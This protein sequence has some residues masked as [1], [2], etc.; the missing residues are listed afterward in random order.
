MSVAREQSGITRA[1]LLVRSYWS[2]W[3]A[4][5]SASLPKERALRVQAEHINTLGPGDARTKADQVEI[6]LPAGQVLQFE[7]R[8]PLDAAPLLSAIVES[9]A[10]RLTPYPK[11]EAVIG[12]RIKGFDFAAREVVITAAA[13][14][15]G[16]IEALQGALRSAGLPFSRTAFLAP[17]D[18]R[19][20]RSADRAGR[21]HRISPRLALAGLPAFLVAAALT[22]PLW[23]MHEAADYW[24]KRAAV[25]ERQLGTLS[26]A[27]DRVDKFR[28]RSDRIRRAQ[29]EEAPGFDVL[30]HLSE[31]F[32]DGAWLQYV[33]AQKNALEM[34]GLAADPSDVVNR[35]TASP[36]FSNV[37]YKSA[38]GRDPDTSLSRFDLKAHMNW[39]AR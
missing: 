4:E 10:D 13:I 36:R 25:L 27:A 19:L 8:Y 29:T 1:I 17:G 2:W 9:E 38:L 11:G 7:S 22:V 21:A 24:T 31:I 39:G 16:V 3:W 15:K 26:P 28:Q 32:P 30:S 23:K 12:Y 6:L 20:G 35:I 18:I 37:T 5:L 34:T 14:P 33:R